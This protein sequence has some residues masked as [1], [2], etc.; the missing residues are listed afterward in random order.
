MKL[1]ESYLTNNPCYKAGEKI[2]VKGIMLHSVGID[3]PRAHVFAD[4]W[5][6]TTADVCV[7]AFIDA[8]DGTILQTLPW[9]YRAWHCG[10]SGINTH[11]GIEMCEPACITYINDYDFECL[12][13]KAA[14]VAA[15]RT[16]NAAVELFAMLCKKF[17]LN[18][19]EDGVIVSHKEGYERGIASKHDDPDSFWFRL[20]EEMNMDSFR[21]AVSKAMQEE[22]TFVISENE[23]ERSDSDWKTEEGSFSENKKKRIASKKIYFT[24][25]DGPTYMTV[26]LLEILKKHH[27]KAS[28]FVSNCSQRPDLLKK[29]ANEGHTICL[30]SYSHDYKMVYSSMEGYF[31]DLKKIDDLVYETVGI[32]SKIVRLPGG[33][34]NIVHKQ[35][36][37]GIMPMILSGL[38]ERGYRVIDWDCDNNDG[39]LLHMPPKAYFQY[40][41]SELSDNEEVVF[42]SHNRTA[43]YESIQS[44]DL[45][46][47]FCEK[48]G[49]ETDTIEHYNGPA[50]IGFKQEKQPEKKERKNPYLML[51]NTQNMM[52]WGKAGRLK[53]ATYEDIEGIPIRI[54]IK[55]LIAFLKMKYYLA[56]KGIFVGICS[57]FRSVPDQKAFWD[58]AMLQGDFDGDEFMKRVALPW[59][60]EHHTGLAI[61]LRLKENGEWVR[62][63]SDKELENEMFSFIHRVCPRFGFIL[64]YPQGKEEITGYYYKP[65][66]LRYVGIKHA[67]AITGNSLTLEEYIA[68]TSE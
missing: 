31:E 61:D 1:I 65:W 23:P 44:I 51:V 36:C 9:E 29:I 7:H 20:G 6:R 26:P 58:K 21:A 25:D 12:D 14:A 62:A 5:N 54:E 60:S 46:L 18:P 39:V 66:H 22:K 42:L 19:L 43:D 4:S 35:Y 68:N 67:K 63:F 45:I 11:I 8:N 10:G 41:L 17:S 57:A 40:F 37:E 30:H 38:A 15:K 56:E 59:L 49:W 28:F 16:Y 55:T 64:R 27:V 50:Q 2:S 47:S 32:R 24:F 13:R 33:S 3:Q 53:L 48:N 34:N 52:S